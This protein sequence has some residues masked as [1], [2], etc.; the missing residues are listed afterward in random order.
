MDRAERLSTDEY[1]AFFEWMFEQPPYVAAI[2]RWRA[3]CAAV[4]AAAAPAK[5]SEKPKRDRE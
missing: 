1:P 4:K 2:A 5:A 3:E